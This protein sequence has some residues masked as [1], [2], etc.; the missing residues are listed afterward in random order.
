MRL[1]HRRGAMPKVISAVEYLSCDACGDCIRTQHP[2]PAKLPGAYVFNYWLDIDTFHAY[3]C[4]GSP[5]FFLSIVCNGTHFH[6]VACM[7]PARGAPASN[8]RL[9][10]FTQ[11]GSSW[12]GLP[13]SISVDRGKEWMG[14][15]EAT[16]KEFEVNIKNVPLESAWQRGLGER[17]GGI[18]KEIWRR[19]VQDTQ[20][21]GLGQVALVTPIIN[22]FKNEFDRVGNFSPA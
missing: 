20:V 11:P 1:L 21:H 3:D 16:L 6:F 5:Y 7:G 15:F 17:H 9:Q 22:Q 13:T 2:R 8:V 4:E 18:W 19:V 10:H 14:E 12:A